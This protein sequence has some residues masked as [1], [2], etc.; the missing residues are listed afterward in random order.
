MDHAVRS[1]AGI[2]EEYY[3]VAQPRSMGERLAI[4]ARDRIYEDMM[5]LC[6]PGPDHTILDVG[7]SDA[8]NDAANMLE[9]K[10]PHQER[11]TAAG[12]GRGRHSGRPF[13]KW[14]IGRSRPTGHC[15]LR[16]GPSIS[17]FPT[18]CWSMS[19]AKPINGLRPRAIAGGPPDLHQ[20]PEPLLSGRAPHGDPASALLDAD[21]SGS[22]AGCWARMPGPTSAT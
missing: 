12:L 17:R 15:H 18:R 4:A 1:P 2:D 10:Y 6:C 19:A 22:P 21:R 14:P 3:E 13:R 7:V 8:V 9:R 16:I 11:I 20:R 5:R